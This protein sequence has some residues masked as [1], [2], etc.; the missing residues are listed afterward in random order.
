MH[1]G[2][3]RFDSLTDI[4]SAPAIAAKM[5]EISRTITVDSTEVLA[6]YT[7]KEGIDYVGTPVELFEEKAPENGNI[8]EILVG[9]D[10]TKPK[11]E[12]D[13]DEVPEEHLNDN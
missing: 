9:Y 7:R 11:T 5:I 3:M 10:G 4:S 12:S 13:E 2:Y 6:A 1:C 8:E